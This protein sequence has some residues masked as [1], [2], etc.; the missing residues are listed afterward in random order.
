MRSPRNR[1][2]LQ[3]SSAVFGPSTSSLCRIRFATCGGLCHPAGRKAK[4]YERGLG[5]TAKLGASVGEL[6]SVELE[7]ADDEALLLLWGPRNDEQ[8]PLRKISLKSRSE[9]THRGI[10]DD[11]TGQTWRLLLV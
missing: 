9:G 8:T 4:T 7:V 5:S 11:E 6:H 3:Q 2:F 10:A 1:R